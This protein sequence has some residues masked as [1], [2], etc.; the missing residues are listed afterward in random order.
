MIKEIILLLCFSLLASATICA[1]A[2]L[3]GS[4]D[5]AEIKRYEGSE[6]IRYEKIAYNSF[7]V[8][9]GRMTKF[10]F[11]TKAAEYEKSETLEGAVTRVS[12]KLADPERSS[13]EIFRNYEGEL[14]NSNWEIVWQANGKA[15]FGNSYAHTYESLKDFNQ[16]FTYNDS[17]GHLLVAK[18]AS[19]N[20]TA[21]L[22]VTKFENGL[23]QGLVKKNEPIIQLD[24]VET[25]QMEK[26]MVVVSSSEMA[27]SIGETGRV[28][29]YGIL[30]DSN[31]ATVKSESQPTFEQISLLLKQ[32]PALKLLVVGHTDNLGGYDFNSSLSERRAGAV[33]E[34]LSK[35]YGFERSRLKPVG[36]SYAAPVASNESEDGRAKNRRVELVELK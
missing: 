16:L 1:A 18:N 31:S 19:K 3:S 15:Q 20:I 7:I 34:M 17:E 10:D 8:P 35:Q 12:Y 25:K 5:P 2:D 4:K 29:L 32:S 14:K 33:V 22:F 9:L 36:V 24:I 23:S 13:L 21:V 6:I 11:G 27:K 28:T 30:F 26:K